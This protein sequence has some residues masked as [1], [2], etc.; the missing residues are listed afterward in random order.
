MTVISS[1]MLQLEVIGAVKV[2][3]QGHRT[4]QSKR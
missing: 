3:E 2:L 4:P 1:P